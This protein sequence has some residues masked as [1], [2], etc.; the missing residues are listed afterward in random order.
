MISVCIRSAELCHKIDSVIVKQINSIGEIIT[1]PANQHED[2]Y[3]FLIEE[4]TFEIEFSAAGFVKKRFKANEVPEIIRLL[5][6]KLIGYQNRLWFL[7]EESVDVFI[8]APENYRATIFR[9]GIEKKEILQFGDMPPQQQKVPDSFFVGIGLEWEK[10]FSYVLP[11][12]VEPGI[13][14]ILL[15]SKKQEDFAIPFIVSILVTRTIPHKKRA[16]NKIYVV[17]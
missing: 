1:E 14:S 7:P 2:N 3:S 16:I 9:H 4:N 13:Y 6:D 17:T 15:E 11:S 8:H 12:D 10:S 5:D